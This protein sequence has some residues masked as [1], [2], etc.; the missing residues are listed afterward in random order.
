[1]RSTISTKFSVGDKVH[2]VR[3]SQ[4]RQRRTIPCPTC[5]AT[6][7]VKINGKSF[8]CPHG[9]LAGKLPTGEIIFKPSASVIKERCEI[10]SIRVE[11]D[12]Y[13]VEVKYGISIV[14]GTSYPSIPEECVFATPGEAYLYA[15]SINFIG[16]KEETPEDLGGM[17]WPKVHGTR[18]Y[19]HKEGVSND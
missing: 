17:V 11:I 16:I 3:R 19:R 6:G 13:T 15:D 12:E 8:R 1:M 5:D 10:Y 18:T 4:N 9:C 2:V 14:E 7:S